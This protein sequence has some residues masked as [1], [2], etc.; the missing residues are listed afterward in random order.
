MGQLAMLSYKHSLDLK[1]KQASA[2]SSLRI[3]VLKVTDNFGVGLFKIS[4]CI[5]PLRCNLPLSCFLHFCHDPSIVRSAQ[6][7]PPF[8]GFTQFVHPS[9]CSRSTL[10]TVCFLVFRDHVESLYSNRIRITVTR[11]LLGCQ[12]CNLSNIAVLVR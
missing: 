10:T 4:R 3:Y 12:S 7:C 8:D 11:S 1:R 5:L 2:L 9:R 6:T